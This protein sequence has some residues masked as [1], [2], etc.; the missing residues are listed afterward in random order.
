LQI[1]MQPGAK[2]KQF[3]IVSAVFTFPLLTEFYP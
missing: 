3:V 2:R 1:V